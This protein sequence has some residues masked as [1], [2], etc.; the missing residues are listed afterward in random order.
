MELNEPEATINRART[1]NVTVIVP[2]YNTGDFLRGCIS[3]ILSQ[4]YKNYMLLLIDDGSTDESGI[5]CDE[6]GR[7]DTRVRVVHQDNHGLIYTRLKGVELASTEYVAFV[8]SDDWIDEGL[9]QT[10]ISPM[11]EHSEIDI[12]VSPHVRNNG[13]TQNTSFVARKE[14]EWSAEEALLYMLQNK[15]FGWT[16]CGKIYRRSL[17]R[18]LEITEQRNPIGEDLAI[19]YRVFKRAKKVYYQPFFMYHYVQRGESMVHMYGDVLHLG[20]LKRVLE[21]IEEEDSLL[22]LEAA[23]KIICTIGTDFILSV[24]VKGE[25][26]EED[27]VQVYQNVLS[28]YYNKIRDILS[29][30]QKRKCKYALMKREAIQA[31]LSDR[32]KEMA[33]LCQEFCESCDKVFIY[34][35]GK[36]AEETAMIMNRHGIRFCGFAVSQDIQDE[37]LGKSASF[38]R[39]IIQK[40]DRKAGFILALNEKNTK[41]VLEYLK[42]FPDIP[43]FNAGKYSIDY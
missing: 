13:K 29:P 5:I 28:K 14:E 17:F 16:M 20:F 7:I 27:M 36:I 43:W 39:D 21:I 8:D 37:F 26:D 2:V 1:E 3:S 25:K 42:E 15:W 4:S 33:Q 19:N 9:L 12:S 40:F 23:E 34:G 6:Y 11:M 30:M 32:E 10:V 22:I 18:N 38:Y 35:L 41:E 31:L 24:L